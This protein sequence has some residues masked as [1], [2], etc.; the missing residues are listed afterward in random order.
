M[1]LPVV[2]AVSSVVYI[3]PDVVGAIIVS[4]MKISTIVFNRYTPITPLL[5]KYVVE[6]KYISQL[7]DT[8][9]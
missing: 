2:A 8:C 6:S 5:N 1:E 4:A 3:I 9:S 7:L